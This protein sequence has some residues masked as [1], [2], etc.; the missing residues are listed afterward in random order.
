MQTIDIT[1]PKEILD[2][3]C[4]VCA[5][6][7][8]VSEEPCPHLLFVFLPECDEFIY[9]SDSFAATA[10]AIQ[11][12]VNVL[13][14][15]AED[16]EDIESDLQSVVTYIEELPHTD[17]QFVACVTTTG[18]ACGPVSQTCY[19]GFDLMGEPTH[20]NAEI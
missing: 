10:T 4:L 18:M 7:I 3:H 2:L 16:G 15:R 12:K 1:W 13:R 6:E 11:D 20:H 14:G 9:V 8:N 5:E 19:Y 17:S